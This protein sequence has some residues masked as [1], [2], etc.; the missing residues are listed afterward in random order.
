[1]NGE[2]V[3]IA[4]GRLLTFGICEQRNN[5]IK[6][7]YEVRDKNSHFM[8]VTMQFN[9]GMDSTFVFDISDQVRRRYKGGV[10]TVELDMDTISIPS[11]TGGSAFD[12]VVKDYVEVT[13]E[14]DM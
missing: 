12:A 9:N 6:N 3:D 11:R 14:F 13:H 5:A 1:M 7:F 2:N 8:D 4:G 10:L